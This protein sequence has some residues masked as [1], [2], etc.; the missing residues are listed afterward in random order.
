MITEEAKKNAYATGLECHLG[1]WKN[2]EDA[3][4]GLA[5]NMR[6]GEEAFS[7]F[8]A[9]WNSVTDKYAKWFKIGWHFTLDTCAAATAISYLGI[10]KKPDFDAEARKAFTDGN[11]S[12]HQT[13]REVPWEASGG[14]IFH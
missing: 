11:R 3:F 12:R 9:G 1:N 6:Y 10:D 5:L 14:F 7:S 13:I 8:Q 2:A 4:R